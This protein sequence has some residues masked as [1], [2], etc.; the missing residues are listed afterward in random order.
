M[1]HSEAILRKLTKGEVIAL[2]WEYEAK[3]DNTLSNINQE[4]SERH[5]DFESELSVSKML[6]ASCTSEWLH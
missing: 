5:N 2:T 6:I 1:S 4:L 3:F